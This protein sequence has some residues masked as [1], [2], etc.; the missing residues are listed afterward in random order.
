MSIREY[1]LAQSSNKS[2]KSG[3]DESAK[4]SQ[5]V[6]TT[7]IQTNH[8]TDHRDS[9][10]SDMRDFYDTVSDGRNNGKIYLEGGV[11]LNSDGSLC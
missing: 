11:Y 5:K 8:N 2:S 7:K 1:N 9:S 6:I 3:S 4:S 10:N